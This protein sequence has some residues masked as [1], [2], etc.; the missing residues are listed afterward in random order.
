MS[1][2]VLYLLKCTATRLQSL[3]SSA[4]SSY[5]LLPDMSRCFLM[6]GCTATVSADSLALY[7]CS[8]P[9]VLAPYQGS[10]LGPESMSCVTIPVAQ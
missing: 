2:S 5:C 10:A 9:H 8:F 6:H 1:F 7:I 3:A 4:D